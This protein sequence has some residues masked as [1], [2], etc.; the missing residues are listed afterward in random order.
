M[1]EPP[2]RWRVAFCLPH[3]FVSSSSEPPA[4]RTGSAVAAAAAKSQVVPHKA[5]RGRTLARSV[6]ARKDAS[7]ATHSLRPAPR[8]QRIHA[9]AAVAPERSPAGGP[10]RGGQPSLQP[11]GGGGRCSP[12]SPHT[13]RHTHQ[14]PPPCATRMEQPSQPRTGAR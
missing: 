8:P 13:P 14:T 4:P 2:A 11:A 6:A 9:A 1:T 5:A 10:G 7:R 3:I 12:G